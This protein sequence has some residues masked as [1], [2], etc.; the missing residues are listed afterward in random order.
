MALTKAKIAQHLTDTLGFNKRESKEMVDLFYQEI[1]EVLV[2]G[3]FVRISGFGNFELKDKNP[4]PGRNPRTGVDALISARRVVT[5]RT[6]QK[7]RAIIDN[8]TARD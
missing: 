3:E 6:G 7:L 8:A 5:F 4:R 1:I 2:R